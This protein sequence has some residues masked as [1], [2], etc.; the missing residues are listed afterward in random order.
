[1]DELLQIEIVS[2]SRFTRSSEWFRD[3]GIGENCGNTMCPI[4]SKCAHP[5]LLDGQQN[6]PTYFFITG[7]IK[8]Q[9]YS[10]YRL[11]LRI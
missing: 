11:Y 2:L 10:A 8:S 1:M 3:K 4:W 7:N 6:L 5:T 9:L